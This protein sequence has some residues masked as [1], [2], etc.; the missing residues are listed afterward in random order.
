[1][2]CELVKI[3][4]HCGNKASVYGVYL[5]DERKTLYDKF[6]IDN[7]PKFKSE[8]VDIVKRIH[9]IGKSTGAREHFFKLKE[10]KPGD[11][12]CALYDNPNS[13]L[14]LYCIRYGSVLLILGG[15]AEKPK[16]IRRLQESDKLTSENY[17]L[18][19]LSIQITERLHSGEIQIIN[20]GMDFE[21]D[22]KFEIE[23]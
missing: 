2:K 19:E 22:L 23:I 7:L 18:R 11:G 21:G 4:K 6:Q 5:T 8:I 14:R 16:N 9:V 17:L 12:V 1:M 3:E 10:G 15:G 13:N 20:E